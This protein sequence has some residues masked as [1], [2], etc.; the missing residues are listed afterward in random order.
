M[1]SPRGGSH[2]C[3]RPLTSFGEKTRGRPS[4]K[5][6]GRGIGSPKN[7]GKG[8]GG[9]GLPPPAPRGGGVCGSTAL[10]SSPQLPETVTSTESKT[11]AVAVVGPRSTYNVTVKVVEVV[12]PGVMLVPY[13]LATYVAEVPVPV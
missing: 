1:R 12:T 2:F 3:E 10:Q 13:E 9:K 11:T 6:F 4:D 8:F 5:G 7:G